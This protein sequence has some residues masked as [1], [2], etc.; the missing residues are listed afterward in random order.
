MSGVTTLSDG[1]HL[2]DVVVRGESSDGDEEPLLAALELRIDHRP[3][4][5][6]VADNERRAL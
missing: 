2:L 5:R 3:E 4:G 6:L 1:C